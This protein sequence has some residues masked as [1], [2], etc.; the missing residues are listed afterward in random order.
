MAVFTQIEA[1]KENK[2]S[3]EVDIASSVFSV[4]NDELVEKGLV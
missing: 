3:H 1:S 2:R 4:D